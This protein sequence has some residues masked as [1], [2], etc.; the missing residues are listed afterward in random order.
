[1][2]AYAVLYL[3][4]MIVNSVS[5]WFESVTDQFLSD[6]IE[7]TM[8]ACGGT[9]MFDALAYTYRDHSKSDSPLGHLNVKVGHSREKNY[10]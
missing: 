7:H 1:M 8:H 5:D 9:C 2:Q 10:K 3:I 6:T 4:V